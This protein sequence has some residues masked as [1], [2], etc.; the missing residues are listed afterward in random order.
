MKASLGAPV[1]AFCLIGAAAGVAQADTALSLPYGIS[2]TGHVDAGVSGNP[3][4]PANNINFGQT[5]NDRANSF[6]MNQLMLN[7]ER[8]L[9]PKNA[10]YQWG[11][12]FTGMYGTDARVT[13]FY[14]EFDR[15]THSPYQFDIVEADAQSHIPWIGGGTDVKLGQYPTPIGYEVIDATGNPLYS[16]SY[17]FFYGL[18]FKHTGLLTTTHVNDTLDVWLGVDTGVN[19]WIGQKGMPNNEFPKALFGFGLNGLMGGKLTILGLSH[20]GPEAPRFFESSSGGI[21]PNPGANNKVLQFYDMVI[22]YK[23]TDALTS[24]TELNYVKSDIANASA[25]G[26][27]TY[28]TY[29]LN[30]QWSITGRAEAFSDQNGNF[31]S[32]GTTSL[33]YVN[34]A[35]GL[36]PAFAYAGATNT[37]VARYNVVYGELTIGTTYKPAVSDRFNVMFRPELRYDT[38]IGGTAGIKPFDVG[39]SGAGRKSS[40]WTIAAD[41]IIG[42]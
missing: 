13:H 17:I 34:G 2:V 39:A 33:D 6:R 37:G 41:V 36:A 21:V 29:A 14:N 5:F 22:G 32:V 4:D 8:D 40:Q 7:V 24:T 38:V 12:K 26:A 20:I 31:V 19:S 9:D 18:P 27:A 23:I 25:G 1:A 15:I 16:H 11:F 42:F 3:D 30:D 28:L 10:G 35:R